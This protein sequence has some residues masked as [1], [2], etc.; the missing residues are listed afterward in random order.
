MVRLARRRADAQPRVDPASGQ[1][2]VHPALRDRCLEILIRQDPHVRVR[3]IPIAPIPRSALP[4]GIAL[5]AGLTLSP[6]E[7]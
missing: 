5:D 1:L 3:V 6:V 4:H 2:S 7:G